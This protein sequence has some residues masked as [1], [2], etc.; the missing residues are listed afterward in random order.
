MSNRK[1]K[2]VQELEPAKSHQKLSPFSEIEQLFEN[3]FPGHWMTPRGLE[4]T[5]WPNFQLP[6]SMQSPK[7]D[8][9]NRDNEVIV[10]AEM[11][12]FNKDE[13]KLSLTENSVTI[14]GERKTEEKEEEGEYHRCE[15]SQSSFSRTVGLPS[16]VDSQ[17]SKA[18]FKDGMLELTL[19]KTEKTKRID[20][21]ID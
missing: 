19:P 12:G 13:I 6:S 21:K 4:L 3:F 14:S 18:K 10:R 17:A 1:F 8:V 11:P 15:I 5:N 2:K 20:L 16:Y 7:V 9:I